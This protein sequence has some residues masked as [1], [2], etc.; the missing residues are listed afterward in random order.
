M[1]LLLAILVA[2]YKMIIFRRYRIP[3]LVVLRCDD[4]GN[5]VLDCLKVNSHCF[6]PVQK[7]FPPAGN[8]AALFCILI[9]IKTT[10][11]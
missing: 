11:S 4:I 2:P 1:Y 7:K 5:A 3:F 10:Y 8:A 6:L 9:S